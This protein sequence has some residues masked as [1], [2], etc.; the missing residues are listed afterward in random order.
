MFNPLSS[1]PKFMASIA[2]CKGSFYWHGLTFI[3][4]WISNH[5]LYK[6]WDDITH[7]FQNFNGET[8]EIWEW[9]SNFISHFTGYV[10]TYL[11][12]DY[13]KSILVNKAPVSLPINSVSCT[14]GFY[15][16]WRGFC[17]RDK[18]GLLWIRSQNLNL[19][20]NPMVLYG[21]SKGY[22]LQHVPRNGRSRN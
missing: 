19:V 7:P 21:W 12:W 4:T 15:I 5:I 3:P 11:C 14:P 20:N 17:L 8:I 18:H 10:I 9:I 16:H 2:A 6:A 13:R 1:V 22:T